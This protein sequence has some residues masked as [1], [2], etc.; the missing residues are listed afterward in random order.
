MLLLMHLYLA[1]RKVL[2]QNA[3][4]QGRQNEIDGFIG[5]HALKAQKTFF[6]EPVT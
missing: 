4:K 1:R 6:R 3:R 2:A 5:Q